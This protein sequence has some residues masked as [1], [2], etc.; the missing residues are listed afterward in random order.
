MANYIA[1]IVA[2]RLT[3]YTLRLESSEEILTL[4]DTNP[5]HSTATSIT[6]TSANTFMIAQ[7]DGAAS[8][9]TI[10][11]ASRNVYQRIVLWVKEAAFD[12]TC[13]DSNIANVSRIA[14]L[15]STNDTVVTEPET[16]MAD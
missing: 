15:Y 8:F 1:T 2:Q 13:P 3:V 9:Y 14:H 5:R 4:S 11:E 6:F 10:D 7:K 12:N 16:I